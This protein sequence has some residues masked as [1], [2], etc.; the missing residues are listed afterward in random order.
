[1]LRQMLSLACSPAAS[2]KIEGRYFIYLLDEYKSTKSDAKSMSAASKAFQ[3][4]I[5]LLDEYKRV[6]KVTRSKSRAAA[7]TTTHSINEST[8]C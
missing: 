5:Y 6:Q 7:P 3:Q 1:M 8:A 4:S 2:L